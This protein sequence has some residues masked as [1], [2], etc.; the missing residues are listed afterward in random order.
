MSS[1]Y[2]H[3]Q[4]D[5]I[6]W[7]TAAKKLNTRVAKE[8]KELGDRDVSPIDAVGKRPQKATQASRMGFGR[9]DAICE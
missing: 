2:A 1:G 3:A 4:A 5:S 7:R 9:E 8:V 6:R